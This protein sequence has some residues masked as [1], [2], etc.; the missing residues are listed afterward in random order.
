MGRGRRSAIDAGLSRMTL[1][2]AAT[3]EGA[4][5]FYERLGF[6]CART[7]RSRITH[8]LLG[9]REWRFMEREVP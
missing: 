2:V 7:V 4:N 8:R 3:N 9:I 6:R 1:Y 5:R